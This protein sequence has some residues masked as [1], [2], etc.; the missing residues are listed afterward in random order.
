MGIFDLNEKSTI[1]NE[2]FM[3]S[4]L[5]YIDNFYKTPDAIIDI[6]NKTPSD[7]HHPTKEITPDTL[8][9]IYF[10][11]KRHVVK[12]EEILKVYDYLSTICGQPATF[13]NTFV[14][15]NQ[16]KFNKDEFNNYKENYWYPHCDSGYN[17][18]VYLN[19]ND[20]TCGPNL[21][22]NIHHD[23]PIAEHIEPW[24]PK[25]NWEILKTIKPKFN[26]CVLFDGKIFPH[27]M[28]IPNERYF[29][30]EYRLNQV[31]FFADK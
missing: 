10:E 31:F 24:R 21:Y 6:L 9:G 13:A 18:L 28:H 25:D 3:G 27:G 19:K 16:T 15:T 5:Y 1:V 26:R 12:C 4:N 22:K 30:E 8:N 29:G 17:G 23:E 11:D 20:D 14:I 7:L 2:S